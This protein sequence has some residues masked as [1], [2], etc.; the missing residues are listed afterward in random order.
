MASSEPNPRWF[1]PTPGHFLVL[2]LAVEATL[3]LSEQWFPKGWA[4]L[5][6]VAAVGVFLIGMLLWFVLALLF[7]WRFQFSIRSLLLL[8]VAVAIPFSWLAV[9]VKRAREQREAVEAIGTLGGRTGFG[10]E[11][12][13]L[14]GKVKLPVPLWLRNV[15]G[16]DFFLSIQSVS[17]RGTQV[18]DEDIACLRQDFNSLPKLRCLELRNTN[19]TDNGLQYL[20]NAKSLDFLAVCHSG[21]TNDGLKHLNLFPLLRSLE[22]NDL[23]ITDEGLDLVCNFPNIQELGMGE[24]RITGQGLRHL[25]RLP[26]LKYLNVQNNQLSDEDIRCLRDVKS[27]E[28][29]YISFNAIT[30]GGMEYLTLL[31]LKELDIAGTKVTDIGLKKLEGM[32]DLQRLSLQGLQITDVGLAHLVKMTHLSEL[33]LDGSLDNPWITNAGVAKL[34]KALPNCTIQ[35]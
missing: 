17:F 23:P 24:T 32:N 5:I 27:L 9:E 12:C 13:D 1:H 6:A 14:S 16:D 34:Q 19:I 29:L 7:R 18:R 20:Y 33:L 31:N 25:A 30:D 8:T 35:H 4:V 10:R 15:L 26:R 11:E 21:I 3:F 28:R 22:I 2:L